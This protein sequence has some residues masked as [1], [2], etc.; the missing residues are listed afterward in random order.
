[1]PIIP[2]AMLMAGELI[3]TT[4]SKNGA[5]S[6][7]LSVILKLHIVVE[8]VTFG[9]FNRFTQRDWDYDAYLTSKEQPIHSLYT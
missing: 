6:T 1:M 3:S 9:V 8:V 7:L 2:F 4:F 5:M